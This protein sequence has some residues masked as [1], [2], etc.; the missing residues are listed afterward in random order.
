MSLLFFVI[1]SFIAKLPYVQ[2]VMLWKC[3]WQKCL[4]QRYLWQRCLRWKYQTRAEGEYLKKDKVGRRVP[5]RGWVSDLSRDVVTSHWMAEKFAG[6]PSTQCG[7]G[8]AGTR[9]RCRVSTSEGLQEIAFHGTCKPKLMGRYTERVAIPLCV[10]V[11]H[12][13]GLSKVVTKPRPDWQDLRETECSGAQLVLSIIECF[14]IHT[15]HGPQSKS[16]KK[17]NAAARTRKRSPFLLQR[18]LLTT[19][20]IIL[21]VKRKGLKNPVHFHRA[22][23]E[24]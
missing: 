13:E 11:S 7:S 24:E 20:H 9:V 5:P 3:L 16:K 22:G 14:H 17:Q 10:W 2:F 1:L 18:P 12:Q 21:T 8:T 4:W 19:F 15:P 6:L 23:I